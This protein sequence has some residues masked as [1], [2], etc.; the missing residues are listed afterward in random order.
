MCL[1]WH[2]DRVV[3]LHTATSQEQVQHLLAAA[4]PMEQNLH[5]FIVNKADE[6]H[7]VIQTNGGGRG[8]QFRAV[9][10]GEKSIGQLNPPVIP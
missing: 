10:L 8:A 2:P 9:R 5:V 4:P 6:V 3:G 7:V 1:M